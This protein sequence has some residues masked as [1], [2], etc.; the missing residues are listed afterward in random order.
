MVIANR[1]FTFLIFFVKKNSADDDA[2]F[3]IGQAHKPYP[4]NDASAFCE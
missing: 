1:F 4:T 2:W 3:G